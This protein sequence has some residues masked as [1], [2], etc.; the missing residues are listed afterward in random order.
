MNRFS[1]VFVCICVL[2]CVHTCVCV[3]VCTLIEQT[4]CDTESCL[5]LTGS[6]LLHF[7]KNTL[8]VQMQGDTKN[9]CD[10]L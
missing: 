8:V 5:L 1:F 3:C 10:L 4:V 6:M 9:L 7:I 2:V